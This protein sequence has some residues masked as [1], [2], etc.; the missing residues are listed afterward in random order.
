MF[1]ILKEN[2]VPN[3]SWQERKLF[4]SAVVYTIAVKLFPKSFVAKE[5]LAV[6]HSPWSK[7]TSA[8]VQV[9]EYWKTSIFICVNFMF[10]ELFPRMDI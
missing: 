6:L 5:S 9:H 8:S 4:C 7:L 10:R 1:L 2:R 3:S